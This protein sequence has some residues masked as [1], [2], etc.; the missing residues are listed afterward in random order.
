MKVLKKRQLRRTSVKREPRKVIIS[1]RL[2]KSEANLLAEEMKIRRMAGIKSLKQFAR[3]LTIDHALR[4]T[5]YVELADMMVAPDCRPEDALQPN[6]H[7]SDS[8]FRKVLT[9]FLNTPENWRKLRFFMLTAG[10]PKEDL[11]RYNK[12]DNEQERLL[13]AQDVIEKMGN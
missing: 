10:W 7:I 9:N 11:H 6:C 1:F 2:K 13:I 8:R 3:K 4:R 5:V 12:A